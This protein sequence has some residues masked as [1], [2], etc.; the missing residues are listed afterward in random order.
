MI[1]ELKNIN[2]SYR[3]KQILSNFNLQVQR[4]EI[5][6]IYG[7][8]G[9]GKSTILNIAGLLDDFQKGELKLLGERAPK[10]NSK[11]ALLLKRNCIS[12]LFQ[13]Y[14]LIE[15]QSIGK[16]L[17]VALHYTDFSNKEK[18]KLKEGALDKVGLSIPLNKKVYELSGGEK[19]RIALARVL[20]KPSKLI[21][22]DEP[23]GSLDSEN[24]N[25]IL[26]ILFQ[27]HQLGKTLIIVTHDRY[28]L[29]R[30]NRHIELL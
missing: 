19:Q 11:K 3:D 30:C 6:A 26:D 1:L 16:N 12:Y 29:N 24:R 18:I 15:S 27:E 5:L 8:S 21:L 23:T 17:E 2:K 4:N 20:L 9:T 22:A 7:K 14:A 25:N 10:I 28:I 13:N